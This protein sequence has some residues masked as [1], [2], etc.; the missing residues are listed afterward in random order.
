MEEKIRE[1][2]SIIDE[3]PIF[4]IEYNKDGTKK[5]FYILAS[6]KNI[7]EIQIRS[8]ENEL[9]FKY[10]Q[11]NI[12]KEEYEKEKGILENK[13]NDQNLIYDNLIF[14]L[15]KNED[16]DSLKNKI[17]NANLNEID[18]ER[19]AKSLESIAENKINDFQKNNQEFKKE[20]IA[21]WNFKYSIIANNYAKTRELESFILNLIG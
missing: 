5:E 10:N 16:L 11:G 9:D 7:K 12:S 20:D 17:K 19:L 15:I 13:L 1:N 8:D 6:E 2:P 4:E 18:L 3:Y 14:K 21:S